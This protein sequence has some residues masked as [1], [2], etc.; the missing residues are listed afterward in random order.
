MGMDTTYRLSWPKLRSDVYVTHFHSV[1]YIIDS[2]T[3]EN[4]SKESTQNQNQPRHCHCHSHHP[5]ITDVAIRALI[6]R[7]VVDALDK[8]EIQRTNNLNGDGSQGSGS[9][10]TRHVRPTVENQVKFDTCTLHGVAL[11]WW[12]S[13]V[14]TVGHD[15][16]YDVPWNTLMK[17]TT[18]KYC[19]RNEINKLEIEIWELK[20][21]T[22]AERQIEKK[23]KQDDN[24]QQQNKRQNTGMAY[25]AGS[26]KKREYGGSLPKCSKCN[27]H[28]NGPCAPKCHKCNKVGHLA[29]DRRSSGNSNTGNNQRTTRDNQR[30]NVC[31]K[32]GA[33]RHFK[34]KCP[35][36]KSNNHGNQG[37]N[38]NAPAKVYVVGNTGTNRD[39]NVIK[40]TFLLNNRYA[41]I[42]FDTSADKSFVSTAFSS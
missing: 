6:S 29:H 12:K 18:A 5:P 2:F 28:H 4:A 11:T 17:M 34:R 10:I 31:Y 24:Q 16:A 42:L 20:I 40:G 41:S 25:T 19:P 15:A 23:R 35:K 8:H 3:K 36:L 7:G 26:S 9:G 13:H 27:Y 37:G 33:Q 39:S 14:K 1:I 21:R 22:F 38:G 32:C 30:G